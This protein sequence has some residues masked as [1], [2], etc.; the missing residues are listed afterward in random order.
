MKIF[1]YLYKKLLSLRYHVKI[2][3]EELLDT[4][5][6]LILPN[7]VALIDP[8]ILL[9]FLSKYKK[10]HPLADNT[11]YENPFLRPIFKAIWAIGINNSIESLSQTDLENAVQ[12]ITQELKKGKNIVVYPSGQLKT[13][14]KEKI[15]GKKV[16][17]EVMKKI[18]KD[19]DI[20]LVR[21]EG[22]RGSS[23][24]KAR[25]WKTPSLIGFIL[26]WL[27]YGLANLIFF[28]PK[29]EVKIYIENITDEAKKHINKYNLNQFNKYLE[30]KY[31]QNWEEELLY[32][33]HYFY[34]NNT[35]DRKLPSIEWS[36]EVLK[37]V[38]DYTNVDFDQSV[39]ENIVKKIKEIKQIDDNKN[40]KSKL[41]ININTHLVF[42]LF[43]DSLDTA[44]LKSFVQE[45]YPWAS[46]PPLLDL[47][48][49]G[50]Y[51]MMWMW[52]STTKEEIKECNWKFEEKSDSIFLYDKV[53]E[54]TKENTIPE[55]MKKAFKKNK[56]ESFCYD[57]AFGLQS[58]K[59]YLIK[60]Y[61]IA[62]L[63]K[64]YPGN[65]IGIMLPAL[66]GTSL[67]VMA[68]YL[69]GKI[70]VMINW[71]QSQEAFEHCLKYQKL[72]AIITS[73]TFYNK[74]KLD[75]FDEHPMIFLEDMLKKIS[76]KQKLVAL[77][78]SY[79]MPIA[80]QQKEAVILFTSGS[81]WLPKAVS[82]TH[83]NIIQN[84]KW[85]FQLVNLRKDDILLGFLP[86]FHSFGFTITTICPLITGMRVV[87]SPDPNDAK[88]LAG[89]V[90][91]T[92][93]TG[94]AATP[95]FFKG[96]L[97]SWSAEQLETLNAVIVWAEKCPKEIFDSLAKKL[98]KTKLV[99]WYGI[100]ECSPVISVNP[101]EKP[102]AG[103][104]GLP[105]IWLEVLIL[106]LETNK[107]IKQKWKEWMIFVSG[108]SVFGWYLDKKLE[109]PFVKIGKKNFYKTGDLWYLDKDWYIVI[110]GRLKRF[111][112]IAG[113]MISL[114]YIEQVF[115]DKYSKW[116]EIIMAIEAIELDDWK[117]K[118]AFFIVDKEKKP[119]IKELNDYLR[120][121]WVSNL[122]SISEVIVVKEIPVLW[123][124]KTDYKVLKA[125]IK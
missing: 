69:A 108:P 119:N 112:K 107:E 35:K 3:W 13:Q 10:L 44:E 32:L 43:F 6:A 9:A 41:K 51:V 70:P 114:P 111:I 110:S 76:L 109:N 38:Q 30:D 61:L 67:L 16:V 17:Y 100:T 105:I 78:K 19:T 8:Q 48:L 36:E 42:D 1:F 99:E 21:M 118:I 25:I 47:K 83:Q 74:V 11:Y 94:L 14:A 125:M 31:N 59:N 5:W 39:L 79:R 53:K 4:E 113:E 45:Q 50:D 104:V 26:K 22:L 28:I 116:D 7:H 77:Y 122:V 27:W 85:S 37:Q 106:D 123:T 57:Q 81:E 95:T 80:K 12:T 62:D 88:T 101:L 55:L 103:T 91:H 102:K 58:K 63:L 84:I 33:K 2:E 64:K 90:E 121:R 89:L 86:P 75:Y 97:S 65:Y 40:N 60:A 23:S 93:I 73:K 46:N 92:K 49:V 34:Y 71:T 87:Y 15:I 82:L 115:L 52:K 20:L 54:F 56:S 124:G 68:T 18:P 96:I 24:S 117:A 120:E 72:P 98:P 29:R 66:T